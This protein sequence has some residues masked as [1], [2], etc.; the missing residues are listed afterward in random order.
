MYRVAI[1][2]EGPSDH[3]IILSIIDS[4]LG[5]PEKEIRRLDPNTANERRVAGPNAWLCSGQ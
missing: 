2:S 3:A 4:Y 1:I 5:T